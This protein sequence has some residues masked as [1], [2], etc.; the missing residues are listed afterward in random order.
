[1]N[2]Y[3]NKITRRIND[4]IRDFLILPIKRKQLTNK[5]FTLV[6]N[7]CNGGVITHDLGLQFKS[8][9]VNL[10]F[11]QTGFFD[12]IEN[13][14]YYLEQSIVE[15]KDDNVAYPIGKI[16]GGEKHPDIE[17]HF[18]HY[19][20]FECAIEKWNA[21]KKR[22][23]KENIFIMWTFFGDTWEDLFER[24]EAL[25]YKNKVAFVNNDYGKKYSSLY[26]IKG[27]EKEK[28]LGVLSLYQNLFGKKYYDQFDY[29]KW[30][31]TGRW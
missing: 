17:V 15:V 30:F 24:F 16:Y 2:L 4:T 20:N 31:N 6:C 28:G 21:R 14:E 19:D 26:Y 27:F 3:N 8:P 12:F 22:I 25:P 13:M 18:M 10:F 9:T 5:D 11:P 23:N 29:V 1:M 7:N